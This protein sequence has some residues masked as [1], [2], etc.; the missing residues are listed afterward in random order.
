MVAKKR[1]KCLVASTDH[2]YNGELLYENGCAM[3][4]YLF[5]FGGCRSAGIKRG[6][7][8]PGIAFNEAVFKERSEAGRPKG[9]PGRRDLRIPSFSPISPWSGILDY[10]IIIR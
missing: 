9:D 5:R 2:F 1:N 3:K 6:Q 7:R 4:K 10:A 8:E